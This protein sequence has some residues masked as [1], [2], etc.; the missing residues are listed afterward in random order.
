VIASLQGKAAGL[1]SGVQIQTQVRDRTGSYVEADTPPGAGLIVGETAQWKYLVTNVFHETLFNIVVRNSLQHAVVCT[2]DSLPPGESVECSD[3]STIAEG[4]IVNLGTVQAIAASPAGDV[5]VVAENPA[6]LK[7][8]YEKTV[9]VSSWV[10]SG[11]LGGIDGA[12]EYCNILAERGGLPGIYKAW[13]ATGPGDS[14]A[15]RFSR[16]AVAYVLPNGTAIAY[17]WA[18]L[19]D[20]RLAH[21]IDIDEYGRFVSSSSPH[22]WT[23]VAPNGTPLTTL[24]SYTCNG[25][26]T[27]LW[28][29]YVGNRYLSDLRWTYDEFERPNCYETAHLYCFEQ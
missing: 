28:R 9:F 17:G 13:L 23:N 2:V 21:P 14:P 3:S 24:Y 26:S 10:F 18:D 22:V 11:R 29:G 8:G 19:T 20:G 6:Y 15:Q 4:E 1:P 7:G 27:T 5:V 12:D 16:T 25:W